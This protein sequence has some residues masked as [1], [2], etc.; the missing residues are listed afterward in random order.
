MCN[1]VSY[2]LAQV[3]SERLRSN[4]SSLI[5]EPVEPLLSTCF[6]RALWSVW[7]LAVLKAMSQTS[8][9]RQKSF[10]SCWSIDEMLCRLI[11]AALSW[12]R[13]MVPSTRQL[14]FEDKNTRLSFRC[15]LTFFNPTSY[16]SSWPPRPWSL[17]RLQMTNGELIS[18]PDAITS[19]GWWKRLDQHPRSFVRGSPL[20]SNWFSI[21]FTACSS[22]FYTTLRI[23]CFSPFSQSVLPGAVRN[24]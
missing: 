19:G 14:G 16:F 18:H 22:P 23:K 7:Y 11:A 3:Q 17:R 1:T 8:W 4:V 21:A 20:P 9:T 5:A 6:V 10:C 12:H 15:L 24:R 2:R 13:T